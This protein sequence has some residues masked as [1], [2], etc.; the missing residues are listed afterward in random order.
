SIRNVGTTGNRFP[1]P[2]VASVSDGRQPGS[3]KPPPCWVPGRSGDK[4]RC[5]DSLRHMAHP[6]TQRIPRGAVAGYA[7]G[8][9][10]TGGFGTL[11]GLVLAYYLTDTLAVPALLATLVVVVPK[12]WDVVI[13][14]AVGALSVRETR[15]RGT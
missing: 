11:P 14:P 8:S 5:A 4:R 2:E 3:V 12:V 7:A 15:G 13:D 6:A 9:V 1:L 10:G